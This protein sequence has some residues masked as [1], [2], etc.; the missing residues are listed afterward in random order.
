MINASRKFSL[1]IGTLLAVAV[2]GCAADSPVAPSAPPPPAAVNANLL[3]D[4]VGVVGFLK[5]TLLTC[6][7]TQ[8]DTST[9]TVGPNGGLV[10]VGQHLLVIPPGALGSTVQ[11]HAVA[12]AGNRVMVD[13]EPSGLRFKKP[14]LLSMSI[15]QCGLLKGLTAKIVYIDDQETILET[16]PALLDLLTRHV[17]APIRH[18][19]HY[20]VAE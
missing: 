1:A 4:V 18:F 2:L 14:P 19:S 7:V 8:T 10:R 20:A 6:N 12:P 5:P 9:T 15:S 3:G 16:L 13:F 17:S 11:I